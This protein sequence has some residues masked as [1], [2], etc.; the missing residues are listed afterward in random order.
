MSSNGKLPTHTDR[1][2]ELADYIGEQDDDEPAEVTENHFHLP[3]GT[4]L[5]ADATGK[6]RAISHD[7]ITLTD[8]AVPGSDPPPSKLSTLAI[9]WVMAKKFPPWGAVAVAI[10]A[11]VAYVLLHR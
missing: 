6:L 4:T 9:A 2:R 5:E 10:A 1:V 8:H 11:I 3:K 7:E